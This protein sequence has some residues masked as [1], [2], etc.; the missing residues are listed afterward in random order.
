LIRQRAVDWNDRNLSA[1]YE[2]VDSRERNP[3]VLG[4]LFCGRQIVNWSFAHSLEVI[5]LLNHWNNNSNLLEAEQTRK[6]SL[7]QCNAATG[8]RE[9][10]FDAHRAYTFDLFQLD[11]KQLDNLPIEGRYK[12]ASLPS[13]IS[14]QPLRFHEV[15]N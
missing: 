1:L 11:G 14:P 8:L 5:R 13:A 3:Q 4:R 2:I 15:T 6:S 12:L 7:T 10:K 9:I